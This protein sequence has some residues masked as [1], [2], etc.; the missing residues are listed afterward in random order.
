M[1][2]AP[3]AP[4]IPESGSTDDVPE[5]DSHGASEPVT[6]ADSLQAILEAICHQ[7]QELLGGEGACVNRLLPPGDELEIRAATGCLSTHVGARFTVDASVSG[8]ALRRGGP[9]FD[10]A[11]P[12]SEIGREARRLDIEIAAA[13]AV[14]LG[15]PEDPVGTLAVVDNAGGR[16]FDEEDARLLS[17]FGVPAAIAIR[18]AGLFAEERRRAR[19]LALDR[20]QRE[21]L[22]RQLRLLHQASLALAR[23][24]PLDELLE[25]VAERARL[26]TGARYA[27]VGVLN[28]E[29]DGI[30]RFI[31]A[32]LDP[33][34]RARYG[35]PPT[36]KG[37]LGAVIEEGRTLRVRDVGEDDRS[38]GTPQGHHDVTSFLGV[39]IRLGA[40]T[41]GNLYITNREDGGEFS[42]RDAVVVEMLAAHAAVALQRSRHGQER[43]ELIGTLE[44]ARRHQQRLTSFVSHDVRNSLSG[45]ALWA[46]RL[47]RR[48]DR[49][50]LDLEEIEEMTRKILRGS[51]HALRLVRDV[52]DLSRLESGRL[53]VW[54]RPVVLADAVGAAVDAVAPD[55]AHRE[56]EIEMEEIPRDLRAVAD[57]D[58]VLQIVTNLLSN[59]VK[60][61]PRGE[62]VVVETGTRAGG[63]EECRVEAGDGACAWI[64]VEDRG[65]GIRK[66][67]QDRIFG[68]YDRK[69]H[70]A[71]TVFGSG[72]GLTLSLQL[73]RLMGGTITLESEQGKGS[74][75]T[76]WIP[77][78]G[79]VVERDG[80]IG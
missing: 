45:V 71:D 44:E 58:R 78:T 13:I 30:S 11:L 67:D 19:S 1:S 53:E 20:H 38:H 27:A 23:E 43:E 33:E 48:L 8:S 32:G 12:G 5:G 54:P 61:S 72:I 57:P 39:P 49:D 68:L 37:L 47:E 64:A 29:G 41:F 17:A 62:S 65:P 73:A 21:K 7:A 24:L 42:A 15:D 2:S 36:G 60:F 79:D 14:V 10:N 66:E 63:P 18:S 75:F 22:V 51:E 35:D 50:A 26:L 40:T 31:T 16:G 77:R 74:R 46:E 59:A 55:A 70:G 28:A 25:A 69:E 34:E 9:V 52:L 56:V 6:H 4:R 80:W 76:L 3:S